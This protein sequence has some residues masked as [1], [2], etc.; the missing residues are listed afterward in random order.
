MIQYRELVRD[1]QELRLFNPVIRLNI[2]T[3]PI[4]NRPCRAMTATR[5]SGYIE[6]RRAQHV[7][8]RNEIK[9]DVNI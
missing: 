6:T 8:V 5:I 4:Q 3:H 7:Q 1:S 2:L 9:S